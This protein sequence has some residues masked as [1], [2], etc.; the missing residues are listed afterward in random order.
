MK[1]IHA[2]LLA[3]AA[4]SSKNEKLALLTAH[5]DDADLREFLR[6]TYE[7]RINFYQRKVDPAAMTEADL[8]TIRPVFNRGFIHDVVT[9]IAGRIVRGNLAKRWLAARYNGF[10]TQW[11]RD[12]LD[13]LIGRDVR[14]GFSESTINK[15]WPNL[16]TDVPYMR[17]CLPKDAKLVAFP[18]R[19]GVYSQIKADGMY[20]EI[21]HDDEV[22]VQTRNG[23]PLPVDALQELVGAVQLYL[24]RGYRY[25]GEMLVRRNGEYLS[26]QEGNGI[27]NKLLQSGEKPDGVEICYEVWDMIPRTASVAK[28]KCETPYRDRF[29]PLCDAM[30]GSSS[31]YLMV[32]E[33]KLVESYEEAMEHYRDALAR[34]LEGTIIKHPLAIWKDGTSKEQVKMKVEFEIDLKVFGYEEGTGKAM[35]MLGA[36]RC[37]SEDGRLKVKVGS[38]FSDAQRKDIWARKD[39]N[40]ITV[41]SNSIMPPTRKDDYSLFLPIFVE[42]RLDK[43]TAD[44]LQRIK[45]QYEAATGCAAP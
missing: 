39:L 38:G 25:H 33:T 21:D 17:C 41:K 16:V 14:A 8:S 35:G 29:A 44:T 22:R 36:L 5:R 20:A 1:H 10:A 26:R 45:D 18:W 13:W 32:I 23:S 42:E 7:P 30:R 24:P 28:G 31:P 12:M 4:T 2:L 6:V 19:S 3:I 43:K 37:E 27:L 40:I 11:E 34:G 15:V 9:V